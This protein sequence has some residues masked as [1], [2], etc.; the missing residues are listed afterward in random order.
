MSKNVLITGASS[1]FGTAIAKEFAKNG[2]NTILAS[3]DIVKLK[4]I[5]KEIISEYATESNAYKCDLTNTNEIDRLLRNISNKNISVDILINNAGVGNFGE[6]LD[7][8]DSDILE[9]IKVNIIGTTYLTKK[10]LKGMMKSGSGKILN[11]SSMN[12]YCPLPYQAVYAASK[13]YILSFS[14]ALYSE[15]KDKSIQVSTLCPGKIKTEFDVK[16][17]SSRLYAQLLDKRAK[18]I[19]PPILAKIVFDKFMG[20]K[21][22]IFSDKSYKILTYMI[23]FMSIKKLTN[24]QYKIRKNAI[25]V[26]SNK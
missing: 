23:K 18:A 25:E 8:K 12:G 21:R 19:E 5:S 6:F 1:G 17:G 9:I 4:E 22:L 10:V 11:V 14:Q 13:S 24:K 3:R 20:G 26:I 2:Y 7:N 16:S 15:L